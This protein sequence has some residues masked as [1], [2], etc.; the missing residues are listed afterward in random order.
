MR[1]FGHE[2]TVATCSSKACSAAD[3]GHP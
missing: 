2:E 3:S 1:A